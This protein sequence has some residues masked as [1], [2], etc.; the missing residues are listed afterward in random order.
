MFYIQYILVDQVLF[1]FL[2]KDN[3]F[4]ASNMLMIFNVSAKKL[5]HAFN[6]KWSR[7]IGVT[8]TGNIVLAVNGKYE[9]R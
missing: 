6:K 8:I 2:V 5:H 9:F 4:F 7:T 3:Q 1:K